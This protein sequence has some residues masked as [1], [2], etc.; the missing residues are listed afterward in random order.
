MTISN[1]DK[2]FTH[3][4]VDLMQSIGP[5]NARRMFGGYGIF[6][7]GLMFALVSDGLLYLKAD[8]ENKE[9]FIKNNLCAFSYMK[10][11]KECHLSYFQSPEDAL[12]DTDIMNSWAKASYAAALR[13]AAKKTKI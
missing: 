10:K 7:D 2:E 6:L 5:V 8:A 4:I 12:E 9:N 3:Y 13:A 11:D 1:D